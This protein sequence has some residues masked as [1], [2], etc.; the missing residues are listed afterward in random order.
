LDNGTNNLLNAFEGHDVDGIRAAIDAGADACREVRGKTPLYWLLGEYFRSI[1]LGDCIRLLLDQEANFVD[2]Y[3]E[4]VLLDDAL[5]LAEAIKSQPEIVLH[6][7][8]LESAFTSL[9]GVTLLHVASEFGCS[10]AARV[11]IEAGADVN[12]AADLDEDG[13]NGHTPI[14]HTVNSIF[15]YSEPITRLLLDAGA[16]TDIRLEGLYWGKG[17]EWETVFFDVTPISF[18]QMGM[19]PQVHRSE[20]VVYANLRTLLAASGRHL[21][22][23]SNVPNRYLRSK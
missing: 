10:N 20:S 21:S 8:T 23:L 7:T 15:N 9:E 4:P 13:L 3:I 11:L 1:R 6:R 18:A 2:P 12:A 14:F 22:S 17:Y 16:R 19:M 5:A